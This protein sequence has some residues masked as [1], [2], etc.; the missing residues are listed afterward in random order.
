MKTER[1]PH[2]KRYAVQLRWVDGDVT[3]TIAMTRREAE[4]WEKKMRDVALVR[5]AE[6]ITVDEAEIITVDEEEN[7]HER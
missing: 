2:Q 3:Q 5:D 4:K 7:L 6:I 1:A